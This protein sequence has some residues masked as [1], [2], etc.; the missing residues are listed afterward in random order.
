MSAGT[1]RVIVGTFSYLILKF[2]FRLSDPSN[3]RKTS[4]RVQ[5]VSEGVLIAPSF[6][7]PSRL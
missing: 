5:S 7:K 2:N 3:Y 1:D 6:L 4:Y